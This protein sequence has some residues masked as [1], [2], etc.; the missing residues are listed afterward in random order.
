M[1]NLI[2]NNNLEKLPESLRQYALNRVGKK[3]IKNSSLFEVRQSCSEIIAKSFADSGQLNV[4][5]EMLQFQTQSLLDE[6]SGKFKDLTIDEVKEAF[7]KGIRGETGPY[8]GLCAKTYHQFIKHYFESKE[9]SE[10]MRVYLNLEN[11][12][13]TK[14]KLTDEQKDMIM[15]QAALSLFNEYYETK[16]L[17]FYGAHRIYDYLWQEKKLIKWTDEERKELKEQAFNEY[18]SELKKQRDTGQIL[19]SVYRQILENLDGE[20]N[21]TFINKVKAVGLKKYFDKL[22]E[23]NQK[24]IL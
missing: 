10:A 18:E 21:R 1:S 4:T 5:T 2:I 11:Q 16:K 14:E 7:K 17:N 3:T 23:T 24:L 12:T 19:P 8:F 9:R 6:L 13:F 22:I 20:K 15:K